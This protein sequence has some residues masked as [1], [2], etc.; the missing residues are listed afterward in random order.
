MSTSEN[1]K[2]N[3]AVQPQESHA[4][5]SEINAKAEKLLESKHRLEYNDD[6]SF[7]V[8]T[9][10]DLHANTNVGSERIQELQN[11]IR[12]LVDKVNPNLVIFTG[13]NISNSAT[14]AQARENI[15]N[16]VEYI[17]E[18]QIPWC[19]VFG[20]HDHEH[21]ISRE[22]QMEVYRS[23]AYCIS[24]DV[25]EV[26]SGVGNYI[27]GVYKKDGSL[28]ALIWFLDSGST[29]AAG[30]P[31]YWDFIKEDQ[32]QW[33]QETSEL[34]ETYNNG[35][36]VPGMMAFH[37]PLMENNI[38][39]QS[40]DDRTLVSRYAGGVNENICSAAVNT[41]LFET[42]LKRG[43]IKAIV[44]GHD[45]TNDYMFFY[46][47]VKLTSAPSIANMTY[48]VDA[49]HG[50][51][52][53]DLNADTIDDMPTFVSYLNERKSPDEFTTTLDFDIVMENFN[54]TIAPPAKSGWFA[55][56]LEGNLSIELVAD[57][58]VGQSGALAVT[59]DHIGNFEFVFDFSNQGKLGR[60]KYV[61]VWMDFT[62]VEIRKGCIG[63]TSVQGNK[64]PYRTDDLTRPA[65][66]YYL[67]DGST[68]WITLPFG[69]DGCFGHDMKG[70]KGYFAFSV[71][72]MPW[73]MHNLT[74]STPIIGFYF[75]GSLS[76]EE[77]CNKPFY[78]DNIILCEDYKTVT[79]P[80]N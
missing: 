36:P 16:L 53:F 1:F 14:E 63:L 59:R 20:N 25:A 24:K 44:T 3:E 67:A 57:R 46:Q 12:V 51:R 56:E 43:D 40:K 10:A 38:A 49:T 50:T 48:S 72:D 26:P 62:D 70:K 9:L 65:T 28:G 29:V 34:F 18:R 78:M 7:V 15:G 74:E 66:F 71:N 52:V 33:Y 64:L 13:D 23:F 37:I 55:K 35:T 41:N 5:L 6:G 69:R 79:L 68:E 42:I 73:N 39:L 76:E 54:T 75:Y 22:E 60:N 21:S 32:I 8:M 77:Y 45:H 17:E 58:G 27:H 4:C 11:R 61:V 47:G 2:S 31:G 19:H 30:Y 80:N